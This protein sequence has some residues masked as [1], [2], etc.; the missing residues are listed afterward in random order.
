MIKYYWILGDGKKIGNTF[1]GPFLYQ[2][3]KRKRMFTLFI[4]KRLE[5]TVF[6]HSRF[7]TINNLLGLVFEIN[8][9]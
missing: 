4:Y 1:D 2:I 6:I 9:I 5:N 8:W 7:L 3:L